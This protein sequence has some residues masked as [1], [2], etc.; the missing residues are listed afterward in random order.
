V[1][2]TVD[3]TVDTG[4]PTPGTLSLLNLLDSGA[5]D[6]DFITQDRDVDLSVAG[7]EAGATVVYQVS[8]NGGAWTATT[9]EQRDLADGHYAFRAI[10]TDNSGNQSIGNTVE[11]TVDNTTPA[12]ASVQRQI[13][14]DNRPL[15]TG[16]A[17]IRAGESAEDWI[18]GQR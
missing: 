16:L 7:Q 1:G 8:V 6:S 18:N 3:I 11:L 14:T 15:V 9:A 4:A 2:N 13:T 10:A 12:A 5:S 17:L